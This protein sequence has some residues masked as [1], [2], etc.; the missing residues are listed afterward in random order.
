MCVCVLHHL[1][2]KMQIIFSFFVLFH[3]QQQ[4]SRCVHLAQNSEFNNWSNLIQCNWLKLRNFINI[5]WNILRFDDIETSELIGLY[6]VVT[7]TAACALC[8]CILV[9]VSYFPHSTSQLCNAIG[10]PNSLCI[11]LFV[12]GSSLRNQWN[13]NFFSTLALLLLLI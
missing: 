5:Q 13:E 7:R 3:Q 9:C 8:T 11:E 1:L 2:L 12:I 4:Q 10:K 6:V